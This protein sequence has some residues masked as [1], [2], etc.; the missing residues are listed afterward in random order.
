[1]ENNW[2]NKV[3]VIVDDVEFNF[4]LLTK[5]LRKTEAKFVWLKD[6]KEAIDYIREGNE[7]DIILMDIRMP[8]INGIEA[9]KVIK[10]LQ[11]KLPIIIQTACVIGDDIVNIEESGCDDII[12]KPIIK[13]ELIKMIEKFI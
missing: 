11:N 10:K 1:M 7:A 3:I 9:T 2:N 5:Q 12:Y 4:I 13:D 6:G 8:N